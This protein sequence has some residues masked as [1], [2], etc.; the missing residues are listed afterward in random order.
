M[1]VKLIVSGALEQK[2]LHRSLERLFP[3]TGAGEPIEFLRPSLFQGPTSNPLHQN[4]EPMPEL[5]RTFTTAMVSEALFGSEPRGGPPDLVIG[6]DD[7]ELHNSHQPELVTAWIRRGVEDYL[8]RN[9]AGSRTDD[10]R[11]ATLRDNCSFHLLVPMPET[12]FFGERAALDRSGVAA[13]IEA[14]LCCDDLEAFETDDPLFEHPNHRRHPKRYL[15]DLLRRSGRAGPHYYRET[16]DGARALE[17][18][19]WHELTDNQQTLSFARALFEDLADAFG[20]PNPL[21]DGSLAPATHPTDHRDLLLR[22]L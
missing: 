9:P 4:A 5:V 14:R 7:L 22:N 16:Q 10:R 15:I 8:D 20:V 11:R 19:A 2:A 17:V 6:V 21:G 13:S 1:R 18:L 12:Y 3:H